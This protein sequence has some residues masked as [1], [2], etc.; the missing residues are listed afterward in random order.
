[1]KNF[2]LSRTSARD[3][4]ST[5][6]TDKGK[7]APRSVCALHLAQLKTPVLSLPQLLHERR[8][9]PHLLWRRP[10]RPEA[11]YDQDGASVTSS[12]M[13]KRCSRDVA[14]RVR[15][16]FFDKTTSLIGF[17]RRRNFSPR[18][19]MTEL[20]FRVN[21]TLQSAIKNHWHNDEQKICHQ[22]SPI[23]WERLMTKSCKYWRDL[24]HVLS[25]T[26]AQENRE[27]VMT[28]WNTWNCN[29]LILS[30]FRRSG[31]YFCR[32]YFD[33]DSLGILPSRSSKIRHVALLSS[34]TEDCLQYV[35]PD[36][37]VAHYPRVH[38][39]EEVANVFN[40]C[41]SD[42]CLRRSHMTASM[43]AVFLFFTDR[44]WEWRDREKCQFHYDCVIL[45]IS[46]WIKSSAVV[47]QVYVIWRFSRDFCVETM[48]SER[49]RNS[50]K[51]PSPYVHQFQITVQ[52][53]AFEEDVDII[54]RIY[55]YRY[56]MKSSFD[57]PDALQ[58]AA[59]WIVLFLFKRTSFAW[60][61]VSS[62]SCLQFPCLLLCVIFSLP[63][64][65]SAQDK[66]ENIES[67]RQ[68]RQENIC[69]RRWNRIEL[70]S[71]HLIF[72]ITCDTN[73]KT[74]TRRTLRH[75]D[76][77]AITC[78][79]RMTYKWRDTHGT[80]WIT[81]TEN[82]VTNVCQIQTKTAAETGAI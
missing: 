44:V 63:L 27:S 67:S 71:S 12:I 57:C 45:R 51:S 2:H 80:D 28:K 41:S 14:P 3:R 36:D 7:E 29:R 62:W 81:R 8:L 76:M 4:K 42:D 75:T 18:S 39:L 48:Q 69:R 35:R 9:Y 43:S 52:Y 31:P 68:K 46:Q 60:F 78:Q 58:C 77:L 79:I 21:T 34:V 20:E 19:L 30:Y 10:K 65:R 33:T 74:Q 32:V 25:L 55:I 40:E 64:F 23:S 22:C 16:T 53:S 5:A 50:E 70:N 6:P 54:W 72:N 56:I 82:H 1:M 13:S 15:T 61:D 17:V 11:S 24:Q 59:S 73:T 26:R 66:K 49:T 47:L 38:T 37:D